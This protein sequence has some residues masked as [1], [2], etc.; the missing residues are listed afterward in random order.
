MTV[1]EVVRY[2][3][4]CFALSFLE[5]EDGEG[6]AL[7]RGA[8]STVAGWMTGDGGKNRH[9]TVVSYAYDRLAVLARHGCQRPHHGCLQFARELP[10]VI[11]G[12]RVHVVI[13]G[14]ASCHR[15]LPEQ[16]SGVI[17]EALHV[18]VY[19][20]EWA[21]RQLR[22]YRP[23]LD[24]EERTQVMERAP[25]AYVGYGGTRYRC[26]E[27][28]EPL[29]PPMRHCYWC[30]TLETDHADQSEDSWTWRTLDFL[31]KDPPVVRVCSG[32]CGLRAYKHFQEEKRCLNK[33]KVLLKQA[34]SLIRQDDCSQRSFPNAGSKRHRTSPLI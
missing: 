9:V 16:C 1:E 20:E 29:L 24:T 25:I 4:Q 22:E 34:K 2:L 32:E 23:S 33:A 6:Q 19:R 21:L 26:W 17:E 27:D 30:G 7:R 8:L 5:W 15:G 28:I 13:P 12:R 31:M 18:Q 10:F 11:G 14:C 3:P